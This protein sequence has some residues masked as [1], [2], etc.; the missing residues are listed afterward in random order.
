MRLMRLKTVVLPA[1]L[2]PMSVKTSPRCTSK[3]TPLTA[4][5]PPKRTLQVAGA[6][7]ASRWPGSLGAHF[8]RSDFVEGLLPLEH[9]LAVEGEELEPGAHL[10]P[11]AVQAHGLE[12][13]EQHQHDAVDDRPAG[14]AA[15]PIAVR[16]A[17][18]ARTRSAA[19]G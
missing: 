1:P 11:A 5:T 7:A 12:E 10:E 8:S 19:A 17:V 18:L 16:Q 2:G 9:A 4:S 6:T 13:H 15:W 14:P 3:L